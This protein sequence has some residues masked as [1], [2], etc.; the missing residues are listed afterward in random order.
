MSVKHRV[1]WALAVAY[2]LTIVV[3]NWLVG[4]V[5][6]VPV[7]PGLHAPAGVFVAGL[8][9]T[10]RD[11]LQR[12][13][14]TKPVLRAIAAGSVLSLVFGAGRIAVAGGVA[15]LLSELLDYAVYSRLE[16]RRGF[17]AAVIASNLCGLILDSYVFL[18]I[19]FGSLAYFPGQVVG[20]VWA[21]LAAVV[22]LVA[23]RRRRAR[24][25][26]A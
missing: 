21:T 18:V 7:W 15:F 24:L 9:F 23:L 26:R 1:I 20:K 6:P 16:E 17:M 11:E 12:F 5:A 14:G 25:A 19:A 8:A 13:G 3:A 4:H 22:V 10:L 2:L